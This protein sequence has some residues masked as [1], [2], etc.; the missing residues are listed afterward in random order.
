MSIS[1]EVQKIF[2]KD[3]TYY[4]TKLINQKDDNLKREVLDEQRRD[5][6]LKKYAPKPASKPK[7]NLKEMFKHINKDW[8]AP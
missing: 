4:K 5:E 7:P 3:S 6:F 2:K 1:R 8:V